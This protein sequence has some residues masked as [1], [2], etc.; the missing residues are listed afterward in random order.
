M[1]ILLSTLTIICLTTAVASA[2]TTGSVGSAAVNK[3][4]TKA[5]ARF[6][7]SEAD[8]NSSQDERFRSRFQIDHG[9]TDWYAARIVVQQDD[10]KG[11]SYEH[12]GFTFTNRFQLLQEDAHGLDFGT[13]LS[14]TLKD[15]DK[16]PDSIDVG[17]YEKF[18]VN[19]YEVRLNQLFAHDVGEDASDGVEAELRFQT[20]RKIN[21]KHRLGLESYHDFGNLTELAGYSAQS[22]QIGPVLKGKFGEGFGYETGYRAGISEGAPDHNFKL[23]LSHSF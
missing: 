23:F 22:H 6:G 1:R 9:F 3:G 13:R 21:D 11:D 19:Q 4:E 17:F 14:Y 20:T 15:G 16:K 18:T 12:D 8:E 2:S 7:F 10:R 5:E